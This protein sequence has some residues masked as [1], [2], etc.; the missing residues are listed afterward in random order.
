MLLAQADLEA[1]ATSAAARPTSPRQ[2][3][4]NATIAV[5]LA[6]CW[7]QDSPPREGV[8]AHPEPDP[9]QTS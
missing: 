1:L 8:V 4:S 5:H 2:L 9:S 3:G 7:A 6:R